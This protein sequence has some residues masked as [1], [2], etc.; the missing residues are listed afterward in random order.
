MSVSVAKTCNTLPRFSFTGGEKAGQGA[1]GGVYCRG[2]CGAGEEDTAGGG[3]LQ[4]NARQRR[5]ITRK[6]MSVL[7]K[8][9]PRK[10]ASGACKWRRHCK[11]KQGRGG[12]GEVGGGHWQ[13]KAEDGRGGNGGGGG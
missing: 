1:R 6:G 3:M 13:G 10:A 2:R 7:G 8:N 9:R 12:Q 5:S 4:G 11:G